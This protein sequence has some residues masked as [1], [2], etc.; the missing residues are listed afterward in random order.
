MYIALLPE[1]LQLEGKTTAT[2]KNTY[3]KQILLLSSEVSLQWRPYCLH[4]D[5]YPHDIQI[6]VL[7]F[8]NKQYGQ[9]V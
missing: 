1:N 6:C 2:T 7:S 5:I 8:L 3:H 4:L 9:S